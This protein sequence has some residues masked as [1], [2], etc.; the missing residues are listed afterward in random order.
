M[1]KSY[2]ELRLHHSC[3]LLYVGLPCTLIGT[4]VVWVGSAN[5]PLGI[6]Y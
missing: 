6:Q 3:I 4:L 2:G 1:H 5:K